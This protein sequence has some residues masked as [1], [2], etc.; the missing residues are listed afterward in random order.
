MSGVPRA[1]LVAQH[2]PLLDE[3]L[4]AIRGLLENAELIGGPT[5]ER[6]EREVAE[7]VGTAHAVG[8]SSGTS[9]LSLS[10]SAAGVT[11][12][13]RE[14]WARVCGRAS[15]SFC[16]ISLLRPSITL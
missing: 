6:F 12:G 9:A 3:L 5:V 1:D 14:A 7:R 13:I 8:T 11:P 4:A 15:P 2:R 10:L 16:L